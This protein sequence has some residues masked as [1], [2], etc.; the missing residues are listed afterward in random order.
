MWYIV[1]TFLKATMY[2]YP[3]QLKKRKKRKEKKNKQFN[4][5]V[6]CNIHI[7]PSFEIV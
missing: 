4:Q 3:T 1:R 5:V 7:P 6:W 2:S